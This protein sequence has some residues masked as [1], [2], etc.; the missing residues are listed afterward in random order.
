M[1]KKLEVKFTINDKATLMDIDWVE[2]PT[3]KQKKELQYIAD[4]I[5]KVFFKDK[6]S[7][8]TEYFKGYKDGIRDFRED[9]LKKVREAQK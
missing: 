7:R 9:V 1:D 4:E 2:E 3:K 5:Y 6:G 8:L